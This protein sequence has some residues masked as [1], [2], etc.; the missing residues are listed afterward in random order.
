M[1]L[2]ITGR[3][4]KV[5]SEQTGSGKNGNWVKQEFVIETTEQ[6]P[7]KVCCSAWGDK[8]AALKGLQPGDQIKVSFNIES[9]EYNERWYTD[10][11]AWKIEPIA[12]GGTTSD[13]SSNRKE[14]FPGDVT[15][16]TA[17]GGESDD[18]PF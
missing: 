6:Y 5:L 17:D 3:L 9:R 16:F 1:A 13:T 8:V 12:S 7:K 14:D 4:Y 11:R 2:E 15:T 10:V 18:L